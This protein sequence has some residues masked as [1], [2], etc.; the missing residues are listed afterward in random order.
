MMTNLSKWPATDIQYL[1]PSWLSNGHW[2]IARA[3]VT[4]AD[5]LAARL[6]AEVAAGTPHRRQ[7]GTDTRTTANRDKALADAP[8]PFVAINRYFRHG[9][10]LTRPQF[11]QAYRHEA[12]GAIRWIDVAYIRQINLPDTLYG[13]ATD[14]MRPLVDAADAANVARIIMPMRGKEAQ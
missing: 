8:V 12:S 2:M 13:H 11:A 14:E 3:A 4:S 6:V 1:F 5:I 7:Y 10:T 9:G